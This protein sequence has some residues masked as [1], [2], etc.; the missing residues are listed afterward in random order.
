MFTFASHEAAVI[1]RSLSGKSSVLKWTKVFAGGKSERPVRTFDFEKW[2][3]VKGNTATQ[4]FALAPPNNK[5]LQV[6]SLRLGAFCV[7]FA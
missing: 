6:E 5:G 7:D 1:T 3:L 2:H 4:W